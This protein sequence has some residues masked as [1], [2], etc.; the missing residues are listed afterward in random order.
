[1]RLRKR[2]KSLHRSQE[3]SQARQNYSKLLTVTTYALSTNK[4]MQPELPIGRF[5]K[6]KSLGGNRVILDV[7]PSNRMSARRAT[8]LLV[9]IL[10]LETMVVV[11]L[12]SLGWHGTGNAVYFV[13]CLFVTFSPLLVAMVLLFRR[14]LRFSVR[15]LLASTTL[16]ALFLMLSLLPI[17]RHR[18]ARRVGMQLLSANATINEGLNWDDFYAEIE[19]DPPPKLTPT[20]DD[21]IPVW[22]T[23]FTSTTHSIPADN[24]MRSVCLN[25]DRQCQILAKNWERLPSLQS[26]SITRGVTNEGFQLVQEI[27][28][29]LRNLDSI[30]TNDVSPPLHWYASLTKVRT[31]F[32]WGEGASRGTPFDK[33]HLGDIASLPQIETF[34]VLGYAFDDNDARTLTRSNS[35]KRVIFRGTS[36]TP[37][38][39]SDLANTDRFVYRN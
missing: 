9:F 10:L 24:A 18:A 25:N 37:A 23:P 30:C 21:A 7:M 31:L 6:S 32:V 17:L 38:G 28:P 12:R 1:M 3:S 8:I 33:N 39:E 11:S 19:L 2:V 34:M 20:N 35:I 16:V 36:V 27:I 14:G 22:L 26:V 5:L 4:K 13:A 29:K 15:S